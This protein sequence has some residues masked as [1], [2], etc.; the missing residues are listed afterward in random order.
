MSQRGNAVHELS[1]IVKL[2]MSGQGDKSSADRLSN[3][4]C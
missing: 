1:T 3:L 2:A 4:Q